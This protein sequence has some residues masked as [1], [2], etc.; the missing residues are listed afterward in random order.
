MNSNFD[1]EDLLKLSRGNS[2]AFYQ[3][4]RELLGKV[5]RAY[6]NRMTDE[7]VLN[8]ALEHLNRGSIV[9][10]SDVSSDSGFSIQKNLISENEYIQR[11]RAR[12]ASPV[13]EIDRHQQA[14]DHKAQQTTTEENSRWIAFQVND[15]KSGAPI[16]NMEIKVQMPDG[17]IRKFYT[18]GQGL[19]KIEAL[20]YGP[21]HILEVNHPDILAVASIG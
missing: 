15:E 10:N 8:L 18:D 21:F 12:G 5:D 3:Y 6:S 4:L 11:A 20:S 16:S 17:S 19:V 14:I 2:S 1:K 13:E 7:Q 9:L